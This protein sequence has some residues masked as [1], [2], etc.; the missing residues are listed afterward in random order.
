[1]NNIENSTFDFLTIAKE[2]LLLEAQAISNTVEN[3]ND[4]FN[5]VCKIILECKGKVIV[6]GM[7]KSGHIARKIAATMA[8]T[9]TPAFFVHPAEASHGDLGMITKE[10]IVLIF[11]NSGATDE[12]LNI[13][14]MLKRLATKI[15]AVTSNAN[16]KI[17]KYAD[18][19]VLINIIQEACPFNLAPT[20]STT[21]ALAIGD[22]LAISILRARGFNQ[23]DFAKYH[24]AGKLGKRLL[25]KISDIM[26]I[27]D[28]IPLVQSN[29]NFLDAIVEMSKKCFGL[30][31]VTA[32]NNP[33]N[34]IGVLSDGDLRRII[35]QRLDFNK[36]QLPD[37]INKKFK[38]ISSNALAVEAVTIMEKNK[39][40]S[41][42]VID[43]NHIVGIFNMHDL[44]QAGIL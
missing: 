26:H 27:G 44:L 14:P 18:F 21:T 7:G 2:V 28:K 23:K 43:N 41:L 4:S 40:F 25:L 10:D 12:L 39:I 29:T 36:I 19:H 15:I 34:I 11:S 24:P 16:S 8:S 22:A 37:V 13:L 3:L 5:S 6:T 9:G 33:K 32:E 42:P 38:C 20:T 30:L 31:V 1:M 17:A 35:D